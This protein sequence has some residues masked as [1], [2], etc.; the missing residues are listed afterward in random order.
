MRLGFRL[1]EDRLVPQPAVSMIRFLREH[2][3]DRNLWVIYATMLVLSTAYGIA[4]AVLPIALEERKI[5]QD[6]AGELASWFA[7]GLVVFAVPSGAFI[8]R[9][10]ARWTLAVSILGYAVMIGILP[11]LKSYP[12][13]AVDR[14]VDGL[15]SMG[16]W[17]SAETLVLWRSNR[18][19]KALATSLSATFTMAG[20]MA[21][22][23]LSFAVSGFVAPEFRFYVAGGIAAVAA[24]IV[25]V[26]L[27]PDPP[28]SHRHAE[29][30]AGNSELA[31]EVEAPPGLRGALSLAWRIKVSC[32]ATFASGFFQAS[33]ALFVPRF[34]AREK[35]VPDEQASLVVAFAAAGMLLIS[36]FAARAGDRFGHILVMRTLAVSGVLG[37]LAMLPLQ[38]FPM[39]GLVF[40]VAGG[41]FSS[42]PPLSLALQGLIVCPAEYPRSNSIFNVFFACGLVLGPF[43]TGRVFAGYGGAAILFLFATLWAVF[44]TVSV[45]CRGDDPRAKRMA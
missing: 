11:L 35:G 24:V 14:F 27:E 45:V 6:V 8:R 30:R 9:F 22:P 43:I 39:M 21:G 36:N 12:A 37:M 25:A 2:L 23:A 10:S 15:F 7:L 17:M 19:N 20:Y 28:E 3:P 16:A 42:M 40:V 26:A 31:V 13:L 4:L 44:V 5:G 41:C 1:A 34:L 18:N 32:M 29:V 33:A 38:S